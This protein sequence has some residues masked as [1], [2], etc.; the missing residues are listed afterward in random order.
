VADEVRA[1]LVATVVADVEGRVATFTTRNLTAAAARATRILPLASP[2][3][4]IRLVGQLVTAAAGQCVRLD[5]GEARRIGEERFTTP[6]ILAAEQEL[7]TV[8]TEPL[9]FGAL[10]AARVD[11]LL[12]ARPMLSEDQRAAA[13]AMLGS[14]R[15]VDTLV[16]PAGPG[17]TTT[18][19]AVI[20]AWTELYG[21][22]TIALA[23]SATAARVLGDALGVRAETTAKWLFEYGRNEQRDQEVRDL[24]V[25][26]QLT[27]YPDRAAVERRLERGRCRDRRVDTVP[28]PDRRA[29]R[30][31]PRRHP[32]PG[33]SPA[34]GRLGR[35]QGGAR[36][37]PG[38]EAGDRPGRR[39]RTLNKSLNDAVR[40][41]RI[42]RNPVALAHTPRYDPPDIEPLT[43]DEAKRI[44]LAAV[45]ERNGVAFML[46]ISL[47]LRR[48]E[49]LGLAWADVDVD[50]GRLDVRHQLERRR[51]RHGC[52]DPLACTADKPAQCPQPMGGGLMLTELKTKQSR[53]SLPIPT[54]LVVVLRRHRQQQRGTRIHAG[55]VW[56]ETGLIFTNVYGR[57][58]DPRDHSVHWTELLERLGIRPAR[59]HDARH[60]AATLLLV[61]GVDQRVVMGMFGWTSAAMTTRYSTSSP[62]SSTRPAAG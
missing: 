33:R 26:A 61:Q 24:A 22:P 19:R 37:R 13:A 58:I 44:L 29:R 46:A 48:G 40:R 18:L 4:R 38:A 31:L 35:G 34:P 8:A 11:H 47:G 17:K 60:T 6:A 50:A 15:V 43:V 56:E 45:Y 5:D 20:E 7:L 54:P 14:G 27:P 16:G 28:R 52:A 1:A 36:R 12:D 42:P 55:S 41:R 21:Q 39:V 25:R 49:V 9:P 23:P 59:L 2:E 3:E 10:P 51:W 30:G 57:P 53:R 32:D 62:S